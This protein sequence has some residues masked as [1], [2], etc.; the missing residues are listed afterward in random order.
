MQSFLLLGSLMWS[1]DKSL[2]IGGTHDPT[3]REI[4][5][6]Q[7]GAPNV[8]F[9]PL[10]NCNKIHF[11]FIVLYQQHLSEITFGRVA[12]IIYIYIYIFGRIIY[13]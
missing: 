3:W 2:M 13:I 8:T 9:S 10:M 4:N 6:C 5:T 7:S 1:Y 11:G 12:R